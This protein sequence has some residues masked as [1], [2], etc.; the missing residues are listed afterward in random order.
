M[1]F[2]ANSGSGLPSIAI[3]ALLITVLLAIICVISWPGMTA[4]L[5]LDDNDQLSHVANFQSWKD[6]LGPDCYG[7]FRPLKNF[8]FYF[9]GDISLYKW[10]AFTL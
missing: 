3:E 8:I 2:P 10:H 7:L 6:N 9:L 1:K 4:P 5:L